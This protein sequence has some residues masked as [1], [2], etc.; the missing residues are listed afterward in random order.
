MTLRD[1]GWAEHFPSEHTAIMSV[2]GPL[3]R[4]VHSP[5]FDVICWCF[6]R[7][8][9]CAFT[10][11]SDNPVNHIKGQASIQRVSLSSP[12]VATIWKHLKR[13]RDGEVKLN[14]LIV[15]QQENE[16]WGGGEVNAE[17]YNENHTK[18]WEGFAIAKSSRSLT[19][20]STKT[21][22]GTIAEPKLPQFKVS[23]KLLCGFSFLE[24]REDREAPHIWAFVWVILYERLWTC[25]QQVL[26]S[27][28][29]F[30]APPQPHAYY[31][32]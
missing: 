24:F 30:H 4:S 14:K 16:Q 6:V 20:F 28:S 21:S 7:L 15:L 8:P 5:Q 27:A 31:C 19:G 13:V 17:I 2:E 29:N 3:N 22:K 9:L 18:M 12:P 10:Y 1:L 32:T 26:C 11:E 25:A 23:P